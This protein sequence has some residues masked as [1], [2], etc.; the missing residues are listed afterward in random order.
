MM[1][2]AIPLLV[3]SCD[4]YADVWPPFFA[5]FRKQWPDCPFPTYLGTND[6]QFDQP[7]VTTL[8][9]G[10]DTS[11]A[12][13]V[14]RMLER[15]QGDYLVMFLEDFFIQQPVNTRWILSLVDIAQSRRLGCL[16]LAAGMPLAYPPTRAVPDHPGVGVIERGEMYRVSLQAA[17]WR[18]ETLLRLL[19]PGATAWEFEVLG[20][21]LSRRYPDEVWAVYESAIVYDQVIEKGKWKQNGVAMAAA[22][23]TP[24]D[25]TARGIYAPGELDRHFAPARAEAPYHGA[26]FA[27][28]RAFARGRRLE[29][30]RHAARALSLRPHGAAVWATAVTGLIGPTCLRWT[31]DRVVDL[32]VRRV[33]RRS[34]PA[35]DGNA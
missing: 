23:G 5:V 13:G 21:A 4:R 17:I 10:E 7:A 22:A 12:S 18:R 20:S 19:I 25:G 1:P 35:R 29:G 15:L 14:R 30:L 24:V 32:R 28:S 27:A 8:A 11:W 33:R 6:R 9:I 3:A 26:R 16:R 31:E 34:I 2:H